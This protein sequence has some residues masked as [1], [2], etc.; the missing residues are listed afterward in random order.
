[1]VT[2][3]D[4]M[5]SRPPSKKWSSTR[6]C[7]WRAPL[8]ANLKMTHP[9]F[10]PAFVVQRTPRHSS[11]SASYCEWWQA[12]CG[13]FD[14]TPA[15]SDEAAS[16]FGLGP[17]ECAR[18]DPSGCARARSLRHGPSTQARRR[19]DARRQGRTSCAGEAGV[20]ARP[21]RSVRRRR[22]ATGRL[23]SRPER[24]VACPERRGAAPD[25]TTAGALADTPCALLRSQSPGI[26]PSAPLA[27]A[28]RRSCRRWHRP[29]AQGA[30]S[31]RPRTAALMLGATPPAATAGARPAPP[32]REKRHGP[33][34]MALHLFS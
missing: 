11:V 31:P 20:A 7:S 32:H 13:V 4:R 24:P 10:F 15:L 34:A 28:G 16:F 29:A 1:M 6:V 22:E 12:C 14:D 23:P 25:S 21:F 26:L 18:C 2:F 8:A 17:S 19:G 30:G 33:H 9:S 5:W 27:P 3:C